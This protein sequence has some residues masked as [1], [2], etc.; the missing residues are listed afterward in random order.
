MRIKRHKAD[1]LFSEYIRKRDKWTCQK[2]G[3]V[4]H[5]KSAGLHCSHFH[6]RAKWSVRFDPENCCAL[7]AGCHF[8]FTGNP[9]EHVAWMEERLGEDRYKA[10][11]IKA[12]NYEKRDWKMAE[13]KIK[14]LMEDK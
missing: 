6:S 1:I 8:Y 12:N 3:T 9:A 2:C 10:L 13:I 5:P 11:L 7:C 4:Y 14:A